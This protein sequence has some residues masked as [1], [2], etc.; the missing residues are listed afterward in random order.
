MYLSK[1]MGSVPNCLSAQ[2]SI[3][4][5]S[6]HNLVSVSDIAI[7]TQSFCWP[8]RSSQT[9]VYLSDTDIIYD[10]IFCW[11]SAGNLLSISISICFGVNG[12]S[13][14]YLLTIC[15]CFGVNGP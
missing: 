10:I 8:L 5:L 7:K 11:R 13:F 2:K 9:Q 12:A 3:C 15:L 1:K 4:S 14:L 6:A